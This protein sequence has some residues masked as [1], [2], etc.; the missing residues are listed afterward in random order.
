M[1]NHG[2]FS[3]LIATGLALGSAFYSAEASVE[4]GIT[5]DSSGNNLPEG[6]VIITDSAQPQ[7][8]EIN[9]SPI[10]R[11]VVQNIRTIEKAHSNYD[12]DV[13]AGNEI[14]VIKSDGSDKAI[15]RSNN[16]GCFTC[17]RQ[18]PG[19][20]TK[21]AAGRKSEAWHINT[22]GEI[23]AGNE[24]GWRQF[25]GAASD[26][27]AGPDGEVWHLSQAKTAGNNHDIYRLAGNNWEKTKGNGTA[28]ALAQGVAYVVNASG[29]LWRSA[30][31]GRTWDKLPLTGVKGISTSPG[32]VLYAL[33]GASTNLGF[34][35]RMSTDQGQT[36]EYLYQ[37]VNNNSGQLTYLR[38]WNVTAS[39]HDIWFVQGDKFYGAEMKEPVV[40]RTALMVQDGRAGI[41][42]FDFQSGSMKVLNCLPSSTVFRIYNGDDVI[43]I[44]PLARKTVATGATTGDVSCA[45]DQCWVSGSGM[46]YI[47]RLPKGR[48]VA[49]MT[50][51]ESTGQRVSRYFGTNDSAMRAGCPVY[52]Y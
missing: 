5:I 35:V 45:Q 13:S 37:A 39:E 29:L 25:P 18:A 46:E 14:W 16:P 8:V 26:I 20:G 9:E 12:L 43:R 17:L 47:Y 15:F 21:V 11:R 32:G 24:T 27:A 6:E 44:S 23:W 42:P 28:I 38:A 52:E 40:Q 2:Y 30:S 49:M 51:D 48:Y 19:A 36:W 34:V 1:Q 10:N 31:K 41:Y 3:F 4:L 50:T 7:L 22:R 33:Q